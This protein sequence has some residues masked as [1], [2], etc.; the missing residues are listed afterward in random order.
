MSNVVYFVAS[1]LDGYI[2]DTTGS[3]DWLTRIEGA[4]NELTEAFMNTVGVQVMG[5]TTYQWLLDQEDLL[6]HPDKWQSFFGQMK[7]V[8]F[9]S[10]NLEK[11]RNA[12]V[13]FLNGSVSE[14]F[15]H[16]AGLAGNQQIWLVGG[17]HLAS[18][19]LDA[20]L[21]SR[22]EITYAPAVLGGGTQ[23]F[24]G[25]HRDSQFLVREV[26]TLGNFIHHSI[27]VVKA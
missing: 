14:N 24:S 15:S 25:A 3:I 11:P 9:S 27:D 12:D 4:P 13:T 6:V 1:S 10:R 20:G 8:V 19:F 26:Q 17:G 16:I 22:L 18:Q 2:A 7:T 23:L 5:S 21:L